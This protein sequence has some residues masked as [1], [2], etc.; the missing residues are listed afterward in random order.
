MAI[1]IVPFL[2]SYIALYEELGLNAHD[3]KMEKAR[4][5]HGAIHVSP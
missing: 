3:L 5:S 2:M 4:F 1:Y